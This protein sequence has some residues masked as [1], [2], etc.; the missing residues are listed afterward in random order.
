M[1]LKYLQK[2]CA[3]L[4]S[5]LYLSFTYHASDWRPNHYAHG[6]I[7]QSVWWWQTEQQTA[8]W[9]AD[10]ESQLTLHTERQN[11]QLLKR[12]LF[13][14]CLLINT[15]NMAAIRLFRQGMMRVVMA[16]RTGR[17][18][19]LSSLIGNLASCDGEAPLISTWIRDR[20]LKRH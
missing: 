8:F 18:S 12:A 3:Q 2:V 16:G 10:C 5:L 19:T 7:T 4:C 14:Q 6:T 20:S 1:I 17:L 11:Q 15:S 9:H 13:H